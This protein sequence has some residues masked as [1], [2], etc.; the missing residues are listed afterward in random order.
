MTVF[1]LFNV[2]KARGGL[3]ENRKM[4]SIYYN[5]HLPRANAVDADITSGKDGISFVDDSFPRC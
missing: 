4:E 3:T 5:K 2:L 1:I